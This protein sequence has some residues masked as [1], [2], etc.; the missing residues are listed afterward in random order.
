[1][2]SLA[3]EE[4]AIPSNP[5]QKITAT[6]RGI[7]VERQPWDERDVELFFSCPIYQGMQDEVRRHKKGGL[8]L[9]NADFWLPLIAVLTGMR[10]EEI[11]QL[12]PGDV[13]TAN[14]IDVIKISRLDEKGKTTKRVKS[15]TAEREVP[16]HPVLIKAGFLDYATQVA[17]AG[18][19]RLFPDLRTTKEK[20]G[21]TKYTKD[22]S[23]KRFARLRKRLGLTDP[24][25]PFHAFRH[26]I[27]GVWI[28]CGVSDRMQNELL[29]HVPATGSGRKYASQ[30]RTA[31][32]LRA[33]VI[34][35][36]VIPGLP[37]IP[38]PTTFGKAAIP[39]AEWSEA[40]NRQGSK[41]RIG[42]GRDQ[43]ATPDNA[44]GN[45]FPVAVG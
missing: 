14:G 31:L 25:K 41:Q 36:T 29:G 38:R 22:Y 37:I 40:S 19:L 28:V 24:A 39:R 20:S 15:P 21:S 13:G 32:S 45:A 5:C 43:K 2:F 1:M 42:G 9:G 6:E 11:G 35:E 34:R 4:G 16:V 7:E 3:F 12:L 10:C 17:A 8:I 27:K 33:E 26:T 18:H 30:T 44:T 23:S